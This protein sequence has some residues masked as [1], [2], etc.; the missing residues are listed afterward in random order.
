M[1]ITDINGIKGPEKPKK[2]KKTGD[3]GAFDAFL[4]EAEE[5]GETSATSGVSPT[6]AA[7]SVSAFLA[8]QE[9]PTGKGLMQHSLRQGK[10]SLEVL[11]ELRRDLLLGQDNA[12]T[13]QKMRD[14]R[15]RLSSHAHDPRLKSVMDDI[16]LRLAV[17]IAKREVALTS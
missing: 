15:Q 4:S 14:Q 3:A 7:D 13:L 2:T 1:K 5:T 10:Q 12:Y 8:M 16:D 9:V 6:M 11:D 17:E